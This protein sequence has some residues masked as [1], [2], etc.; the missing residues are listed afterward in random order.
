MKDCKG[1]TRAKARKGEK[2]VGDDVQDG[3][4]SGAPVGEGSACVKDQAKVGEVVAHTLRLHLI[5]PIDHHL[6][7]RKALSFPIQS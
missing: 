6:L 3:E 5:A 1:D 7:K 4:L 2:D